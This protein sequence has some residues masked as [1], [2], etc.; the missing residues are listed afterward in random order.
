MNDEQFLKAVKARRK[1]TERIRLRDRTEISLTK[2]EKR[3][4]H[5]IASER[6]VTVSYLLCDQNP[7]SR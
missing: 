5:E 1:Q 6:R 2:D 3:R 7:V 4:L